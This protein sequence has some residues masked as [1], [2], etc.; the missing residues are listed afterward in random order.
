MYFNVNDDQ[1]SHVSRMN[2]NSLNFLQ[3]TA[4]TCSISTQIFHIYTTPYSEHILPIGDSCLSPH[5]PEH[6]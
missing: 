4:F 2:S 6:V 5:W 1:Y 3:V